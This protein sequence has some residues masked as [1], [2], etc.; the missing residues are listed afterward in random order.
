MKTSKIFPF[1]GI[2]LMAAAMAGCSEEQTMSVGE[3]KIFL[4]THIN[5]DV[6]VESRAEAEDELAATT[7]IWIYSDQGV[8]RKYDSMSQ[9]PVGGV[10][11]LAGQYTVKA[12]AGTLSYASWTDRWFE[13]EE[14]VEV[15]AN[16]SS[17]VEVTCKIANVVSSVKYAENV[18]ELI[19]DYTLEVGHRGGRLTF[20][21]QDAR[22]AYFMMP[23]GEST[24]DWKLTATFEGKQFTKTG[25]IENV[26]PAHEY[27]LNVGRTETSDPIG[28][29]FITIEVDD[30]MVESEDEI[31]ITTPPTI[32]GYGFDIENPVVGESGSIGRKSVYVCAA[33]ELAEV[34]LSGV[35]GIAE[36]F[37]L[38]RATD[39]YLAELANKGIYREIENR[40]GGQMVKVIF[41]D[42]YTNALQNRVEPYVITISAK[43]LG[44]KVT[45]AALTFKVN[46]APVFVNRVADDDIDFNA[47]TFTAQISNPDVETVGFEYR[48]KGTTDWQYV[49]GTTGGRANW[50]KGDTYYATVRGLAFD[51][52]YEYRAVSGPASNPTEYNA[53][54]ILS[55]TMKATPQLPNAG[56]EE[57]G[58]V[59]EGNKDPIIP[60]L[61][62]D[63][64]FWDC[65][66]HGS[67]TMD[68]NVTQKTTAKKHSGNYAAELKTGYPS[69]FGIGKLASGNIVVGEYK[70]T[71][72]TNGVF[73]FGREFDFHGLK[74]KALQLWMHFTPV[75]VN[76]VG[77]TGKQTL[78]KG[79]MDLGHIF[80]ALFD[81]VETVQTNIGTFTAPYIVDTEK[82]RAFNKN[83][84]NIL[85]YGEKILTEATPGND[86]VLLEIPIEYYSQTRVPKYIAV[87]CAA[88]KEGDFF[89][90]G[91]G[92]TLYVDDFKLVY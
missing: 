66:N 61:S 54:D 64:M 55:V 17:A 18:T 45:T 8:V 9:V 80:I 35:Q 20:E 60:A 7:Q 86:L 38:I 24:L 13:G 42:T 56:M 90:G 58:T 63:N 48:E 46:E 53:G 34:T 33:S 28:G 51:A 22:K 26:E 83:A 74:P 57:W 27:V 5:S 23:E 19:S 71:N 59:R 85:A 52:T 50:T 65:G 77:T 49:A 67:I 11:L 72:G 37:D 62:A 81:D 68:I 88:S 84:D 25:I 15:G 75:T 16:T 14:T 2:V 12:W 1:A 10:K 36:D 30:Q 3:G 76:R 92:T 29:A 73:A 79:D 6:K 39:D 47:L 4:S 40:D 82:T 43:D 41:E 91:E 21:G 87:V 44:N 31:I 89:T 78:K 32:T 69:M 70:G